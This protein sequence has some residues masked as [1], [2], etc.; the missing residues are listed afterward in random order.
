[1]FKKGR[2]REAKGLAV[3][4]FII[5]LIILLIILAV[6]YFALVELDYSDRIKDP[7][8]TI[9]SYV[10][11]TPEPDATE[12][13]EDYQGDAEPLDVDLTTATATPE[14]T[15]V[16]TPTP[17]PTPEPTPEPTPFAPEVLAEPMTTGFSVPEAATEGCE[18]AISKCYVST[19]DNNHYMYLAGYGYVNDLTFDC[20]QMQAFLVVN[21]TRTNQKIAYRMTMTPGAS[22]VSHSG[23]VCQNADSADFEVYIDVSQIYSEDIYTMGVVLAYR[24]A[25][26]GSIAYAYCPLGNDVS[27]TVMAG[28]VVTPVKVPGATGATGAEASAAAAA[29]AAASATDEPDVP[30]TSEEE[31]DSLLDDIADADVSDFDEPVQD[32]ILGAIG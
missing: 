31:A 5:G 24:T 23:A 18:A 10:E 19:A 8:A 9:R 12:V 1:M 7:E 15:A 22:G 6:I 4:Y 14:P 27:F 20:S 30:I 21:Q 28:Q 13:P 29:P 25:G 17:S 16:P 3:V 2:K 32:D 11:L 26:D